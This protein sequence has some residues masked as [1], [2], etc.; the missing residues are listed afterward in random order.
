MIVPLD[1]VWRL[2]AAWYTDPRSPKWRPRTAAES[3]AVLESV[4]LT[5]DFWR[6]S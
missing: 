6:L 4:G 2:A 3:Q 5:G 1:Q